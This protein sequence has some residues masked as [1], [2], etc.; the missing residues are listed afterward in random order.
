MI[1]K[2]KKKIQ[3]KA[4]ADNK[5]WDRCGCGRM[6]VGFTCAISGQHR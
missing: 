4:Y 3:I 1:E 5:N 6:I 2:L